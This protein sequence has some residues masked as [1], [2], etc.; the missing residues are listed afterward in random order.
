M[1]DLVYQNYNNKCK[2]W[3][4]PSLSFGPEIIS[5]T[6][7]QSPAGSNT[8]I[9]IVG[10]NFYSY[11][12]VNFGTFTPTT[13]F[14]NSSLISFYIPNTLYPG[15]YPVKVCNGSVCSNSVNFTIDM[16]S[17]YW[18]LNSSGSISN[19]NNNGVTVSW[20]SRGAPAYIF[21]TSTKKYNQANP[22]DVPNNV[23]WIITGDDDGDNIIIK[24]PTGQN[25]IG[26]EIMI[27]AL[28]SEDILSYSN[29]II[30]LNYPIESPGGDIIVP[31]NSSQVNWSTLV[32]YDGAKWVVM[33]SNWQQP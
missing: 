32:N 28:S 25:Y 33:Q 29:N 18:L 30:S 17:G 31:G 10:N 16:S 13:Y 11:S 15:T 9:S 7:Y 2:G 12:T 19:T 8:V 26:R 4:N 23:N 20:I 22:Y 5:L 1:S 21:N 24:L 6:G 3:V 14:I 27:K